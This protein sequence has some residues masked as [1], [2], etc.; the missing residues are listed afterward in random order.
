VWSNDY[1]ILIGDDI[2]SQVL[3]ILSGECF[4]QRQPYLPELFILSPWVTDVEI[5]FSD[6]YVLMEKEKEGIVREKSHYS[7]RA[8]M[9]SLKKPTDGNIIKGGHCF[10]EINV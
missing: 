7:A 3:K 9:K 10:M 6:L 4:S 2:R 5:E 8:S 1:S